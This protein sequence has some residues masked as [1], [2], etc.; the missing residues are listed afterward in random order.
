V[1]DEHAR[2][3]AADPFDR[4][5]ARVFG[6]DDR[7]PGDPMNLPGMRLGRFLAGYGFMLSGLVIAIVSIVTLA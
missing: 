7:P 6:A 5:V 3:I 1:A 4:W 2:R